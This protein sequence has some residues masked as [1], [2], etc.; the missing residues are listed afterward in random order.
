VHEVR[1]GHVVDEQAVEAGATP[2]LVGGV[3]ERLDGVQVLDV[4]EAGVGLARES[5]LG[6]VE[7][8]QFGAQGLE[9]GGG[10]VE[11]GLG[12]ARGGGDVLKGGADELLDLGLGL[13]DVALGG[14]EVVAVEFVGQAEERLVLGV[15]VGACSLR[16]P[17]IW[18]W[19]VWLS[20]VAESSAMASDD[21]GSWWLVAERGGGPD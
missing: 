16:R 11:A 2:A 7:R 12:V 13:L 14:L 20:L 1:A 17:T 5:L 10:G 6:A 9:A 19:E 21:A 15:S 4:G 18:T 8:L 3:G